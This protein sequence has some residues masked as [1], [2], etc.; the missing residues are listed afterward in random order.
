M[1]PRI[2]AK[3]HADKTALIMDETGESLTYAELEVLANQGAQFLRKCG[4]KTG[5]IIT[6][7]ARNSIEFM[8]VYWAAQRA[9]IYVCPLPTYLSVDDAAYILKDCGAKMLILSNEIKNAGAFL[10]KRD[11]LTLD[12]LEIYSLHGELSSLPKW[13]ESLNAMPAIP[14]SDEQAGWH[15]IYSS[16]TTGRPKG[17]KLPY[18]GGPVIEDNV[19]VKR[20]EDIYNLT[21]R[22]VFLT[23]APLYHSAPIL[24]ASNVMRR[25]ATVVIMKKFDAEKTLAAIQNY[26]ITMSQMVPTMFIRML[27]LPET[28][29]LSYDISS[30]ELVA[31]AAAP[32][33][34]EVKYKMLDWFGDIIDEYYAGSESNG[35][36]LINSAEWRKKP[37]SVGRSRNAVIHICSESGDELPSGKIGMIYF[38]GGYDFT[39]LND[40]EK[41]KEARNPKHPSWTTLGDIGYIDEDGYLFLTDRKNF[42]IISGGVNIYPQEAENILVQHPMVQDVAVFGV[43]NKDMGEE[44][45]AV[46]QP[47][48]WTNAGASL[49]AELIEYCQSKLTRRKCP[50]SIDF[51]RSLPRQDNGK[52]Y[53]KKLRAKY[54]PQD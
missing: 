42:V 10:S 39:Y 5:D 43:P 16:G 14:I 12:T 36:T 9:G 29:R 11:S 20:Y 34:I 49:E 33:P 23:C 28:T 54:W 40:P 19:W 1:H 46:V 35:A 37:G 13:D 26:K 50:R 48:D 15:L 31:H 51:E 6:L 4:I 27:D 53:K 24:F 38:D 30:L 45:K 25:G 17:V 44:V 2:Y 18:I 22:S 32:C 47:K 41:T 3:S 52:L 7:W 21:D 8:T